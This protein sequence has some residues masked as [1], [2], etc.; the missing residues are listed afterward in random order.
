MKDFIN[1]LYQNHSLIYKVFLFIITTVAIVY[2]FPKGGHFG[3]DVQKGKIWQSDN[4][5]APFDF[6]IQKSDEE[7]EKEKEAI[8]QNK[9]LYFA[10]NKGVFK[11]VQTNYTKYFNT[12]IPDSII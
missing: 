2:L 4:L 5:Y 12:L 3:L 1:K 6:A 9:Q 10:S 8:E 11:R 7:I